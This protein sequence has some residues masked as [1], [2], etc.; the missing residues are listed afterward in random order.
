M[1]ALDRLNESSPSFGA[2]LN[3][4]AVNRASEPD[5]ENLPVQQ[6]A[7]R[8]VAASDFFGN[9]GPDSCAAPNLDNRM[10]TGL[11]KPPSMSP[12]GFGSMQNRAVGHFSPVAPSTTSQRPP[13][14]TSNATANSA[15]GSF[16]HLI[17]DEPPSNVNK[18]SCEPPAERIDNN[19]DTKYEAFDLRDRSKI[20]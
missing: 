16:F 8:M 15:S 20:G 18:A 6:S 19:F 7:L 1:T 2:Q 17:G 14:N 9:T 5:F 10:T 12:V 13:R 3:R 11:D 4:P